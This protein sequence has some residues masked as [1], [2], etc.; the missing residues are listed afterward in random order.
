MPRTIRGAGHSRANSRESLLRSILRSID[1]DGDDGD[2]GVED[3]ALSCR[4][5]YQLA[6]GGAATRTDDDHASVR[7]RLGQRQ[8]L[9]DGIIA[10]EELE[11]LVADLGRLQRLL[12][13]RDVLAGGHA[14]FVRSLSDPGVEHNADIVEG[15][16]LLDA[17]ID[18]GPSLQGRGI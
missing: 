2:I 13:L 8:E 18:G 15:A 17:A 14:A 12:E 1:L 6:H 3:D 4:S 9:F 5:H 11:D 16:G 7:G 10:A